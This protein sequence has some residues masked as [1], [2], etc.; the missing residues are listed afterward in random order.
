MMG[1]LSKASFFFP[2]VIDEFMV[3]TVSTTQVRHMYELLALEAQMRQEQPLGGGPCPQLLMPCG[4]VTQT[5][6]E[7]GLLHVTTAN[8]REKW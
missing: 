5:E 1:N 3:K 8:I 4:L 7:R 2:N 6:V